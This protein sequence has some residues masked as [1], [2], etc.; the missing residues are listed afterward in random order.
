[1]VNAYSPAVTKYSDIQYYFLKHKFVFGDFGYV[2]K[3]WFGRIHGFHA[4]KQYF[5]RGRR[6]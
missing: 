3:I 1:M 2:V 6:D 4:A 5:I